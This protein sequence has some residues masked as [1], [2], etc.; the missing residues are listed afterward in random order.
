V[1]GDLLPQETAVYM[2]YDP[3]N[4]YFAFHCR[5]SEP[6]RI[7]TSLTKRDNLFRD[8]WVGFS[9][10]TVNGKQF[11]YDFFVNPSG[12]QG[13]IYRSGNGEDSSPDWVWYSAG[14]V[15]EDGY[16][17]EIRLPLKSFRFKNG[18]DVEMGILFWRRISRLGVSGA[19]PEI[20]IGKGV[21]NSMARVVYGQ[22]DKQLLLE[23]LPSATAGG[24]RDRE[25]PS[26]WSGTDWKTELGAG[27]KYGIT[28]S[29]V[30]EA[31]INPDFSQVESDVF[32][33]ETNQRYP[34]FY[35][36]KRPFFMES[37]HQ[38]DL[39][40]TTGDSNMRTAVH[41]RRIV[42]PSWGAK[43]TGEV[44][45]TS[46]AVLGASDE[47]PGRE[48]EDPDDPN[49][50]LGE[51]AQVMVARGR[52]N[53]G[54]DNYVGVLYTGRELPGDFNRVAGGDFRFRIRGKHE[55]LGSFLYSASRDLDSPET[56]SGTSYSALYQY[57]DKPLGV[58]AQIENM[59]EDFRMD[60]AF[61]ERG[62]IRRVTG[63][64]GPQFYPQ[65]ERW[66]WLKRINPFLWGFHIHDHATGEDDV[67]GLVSLR[68]DFT[69]QGYL[70]LDYRRHREH[71][72]GVRYDKTYF[73]A[74]AGAQVA[75][76]LN[77]SAYGWGGDRL[78]Y[79]E[80]DPFLGTG[81]RANVAATLQ[82]NDKVS[83][84]LEYTYDFL[85]R[86][87]SGGREYDL[88]LIVSR[89]T[90]Q[91][92]KYVFLRGL[93]QHDSHR[94]VVLSDVLASLTV[95]PGTVFHVGYGSLHERNEW[96]DGE[97]AEDTPGGRYH[98]VTQSFFVKASYL[99]RF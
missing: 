49:L 83:L 70:R 66:S 93:I 97:W 22:L 14:L 65:G 68:F 39:A 76:W 6:Q 34:I 12:V 98:P 32:Q 26:S 30:A 63:Y 77:L 15:V 43:L 28:S 31:T 94:G 84:S 24:L 79:D 74:N 48:S 9:L 58:M 51:T 41:T 61:Y 20:G 54:S 72:E 69:R 2:T 45:R 87:D 91:F 57:F 88:H 64:F 92:N 25:Q 90:Y 82:P 1:D 53:V 16:K 33:V 7:K 47:W 23:V 60:T 46:F 29:V 52:F 18:D 50:H 44:G 89:L 78:F 42:D 73:F 40:G 62:G 13:D 36:E 27:V 80:D 95:I 8:D 17:V 99:V 55:L 85:D 56:R 19:W 71:W 37:G 96:V 86:P 11:A 3:D 10:D 21:F 81:G 4:L 5:D 38:F 67:F 59:D 35:S 75:K